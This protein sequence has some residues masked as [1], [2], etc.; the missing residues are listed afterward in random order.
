MS[1]TFWCG[2][3]FLFHPFFSHSCFLSPVFTFFSFEVFLFHFFSIFIASA[4][5]SILFCSPLRWFVILFYFL[6][7]R[8]LLFTGI[9][10]FFKIF[11]G[12][13][14][15]HGS[16]SSS[17]NLSFALFRIS[18][19][20]TQGGGSC[21]FPS[22]LIRWIYYPTFGLLF[23]TYIR[24][25]RVTLYPLIR[26]FFFLQRLFAFFMWGSSCEWLLRVWFLSYFKT[27]LYFNFFI[28]SVF[29][30]LNDFLLYIWC[31]FQKSKFFW[32]KNFFC[33]PGAPP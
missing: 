29:D 17:G 26:C 20:F 24:F 33:W 21:F 15:F 6:L 10:M 16:Y 3:F 18:W 28:F 27:E 25:E 7:L 30:I 11:T 19:N 14:S 22:I 31:R 9:S 32:L 12:F 13:F 8:F 1:S 2:S 5:Q 4:V 23:L